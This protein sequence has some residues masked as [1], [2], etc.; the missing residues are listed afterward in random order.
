MSNIAHLVTAPFFSSTSLSLSTV[1]RVSAIV[2]AALFVAPHTADSSL[3]PAQCECIFL[4]ECVCLC[5]MK[6]NYINTAHRTIALCQL[7]PSPRL[8][9]FNSFSNDRCN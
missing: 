6:F 4:S 3:P 1:A 2:F 8:F 7:V 9:S 5:A